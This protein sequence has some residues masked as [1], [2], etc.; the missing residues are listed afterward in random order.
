MKPNLRDL[1][2]RVYT[3]QKTNSADLLINGLSIGK[4][5]IR[6]GFYT[7]RK[8]SQYNILWP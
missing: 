4:I 7:A 3:Q 5:W 6:E 8:E 2:Q 1:L